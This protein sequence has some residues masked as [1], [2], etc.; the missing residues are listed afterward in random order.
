MNIGSEEDAR[1]DDAG[2]LW[3]LGRTGEGEPEYPGTVGEE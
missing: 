1:V 2:N 3:A